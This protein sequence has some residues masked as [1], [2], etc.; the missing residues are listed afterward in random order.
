MEKV[1]NF[2]NEVGEKHE[3]INV[4]PVNYYRKIML[5]I[6]HQLKIKKIPVQPEKI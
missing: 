1:A 2:I 3:L 6:H 4:F 5:D